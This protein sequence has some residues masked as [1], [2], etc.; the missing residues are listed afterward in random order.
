MQVRQAALRGG[1]R[2]I[3]A[4]VLWRAMTVRERVRASS[5]VR[6]PA[7]DPPSRAGR[8]RLTDWGLDLIAYDFVDGDVDV[9]EDDLVKLA[10]DILGLFNGAQTGYLRPKTLMTT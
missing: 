4:A 1:F 2:C 10:S 6:D 9:P 5:S 3:G 8:Q 7:H